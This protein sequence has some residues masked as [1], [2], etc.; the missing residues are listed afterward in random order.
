MTFGTAVSSPEAFDISFD[1]KV[2]S[3]R[4]SDLLVFELFDAALQSTGIRD[5]I[6]GEV[7]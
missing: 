2:S 1:C 4:N 3:F 6:S 7:D 5:Q